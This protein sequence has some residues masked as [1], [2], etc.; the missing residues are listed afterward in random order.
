MTISEE[1]TAGESRA[2]EAGSQLRRQVPAFVMVGIFGVFV[3][4]GVTYALARGFHV[5][6]AFARPPAFAVATVL[7]FA[8]NRAL[9]F[10]DSGA[11]L[12]RAFVRYVMVCAAGLVINYA[13]YL[14][15]VAASPLAGIDVNQTPEILPLFVAAGS[16]VAMVVTFIGFR[17]FAFRA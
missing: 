1:A 3:D 17:F 4:A 2:V 13:V 14:A 5:A 9:T 7:N 10:R 6:P 12:L 8:L 16:A 15:C 11:P